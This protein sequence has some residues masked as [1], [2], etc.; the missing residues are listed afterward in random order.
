MSEIKRT[1]YEY[2]SGAFGAPNGT[3]E[4]LE[5]GSSHPNTHT[6]EPAAATYAVDPYPG[7]QFTHQIHRDAYCFGRNKNVP[8]VRHPDRRFVSSLYAMDVMHVNA[9]IAKE[10]IE[11]FNQKSKVT[12]PGVGEREF[13]HIDVD[14]QKTLADIASVWFPLGVCQTGP[15][16]DAMTRF[17]GTATAVYDHNRRRH[18]VMRPRGDIKCRNYWGPDLREGDYCYFLLKFVPVRSNQVI[19]DLSANEQFVC[20]KF[21][22]KPTSYAAGGGVVINDIVPMIPAIVPVFFRGPSL[23]LHMRAYKISESESTYHL[24]VVY[25]VGYCVASAAASTSALKTSSYALANGDV[26][27]DGR[28]IE[29][30]GR[31]DVILACTI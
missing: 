16:P 9:L 5:A 14:Q 3:G 31:I 4:A 12:L 10:Y 2:D 20:P 8:A 13:L 7:V 17:P 28:M 27:M 18:L 25:H 19:Y 21:N 30:N 22:P 23:P 15:N 24:G 29:A 1:R 6:N 26:R 11:W